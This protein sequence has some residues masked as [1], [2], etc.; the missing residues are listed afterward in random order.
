MTGAAHPSWS[1]ASPQILERNGDT[2]HRS[3][4]ELF[5]AM[6]TVSVRYVFMASLPHY[7]GKIWGFT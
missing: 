2:I 3:R 6:Y 4:L 1:D 5:I 7:V